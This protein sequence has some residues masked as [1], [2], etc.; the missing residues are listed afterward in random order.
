MDN[1]RVGLKDKYQPF[2]LNCRAYS[3]AEFRDAP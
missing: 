3:Q 1:A 2:G